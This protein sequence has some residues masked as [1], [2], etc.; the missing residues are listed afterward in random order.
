MP[1]INQLRVERKKFYR[2]LRGSMSRF[3]KAQEKLQSQIRSVLNRKLNVP[4]TS[5]Y[6]S[7]TELFTAMLALLSEFEKILTRG[8]ID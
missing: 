4:D 3:N 2:E 8:F 1:T 6:Q 5:D 7:T